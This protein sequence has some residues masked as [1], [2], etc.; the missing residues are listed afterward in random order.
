MDV[1]ATGKW[2]QGNIADNAIGAS[3]MADD[4]VGVAELSATGTASATTFLRGD[5]SWQSA[6]PAADSI[7]NAQINTSAAIAQSKLANVAYYTSS[8]TAPTS[9]TPAAGNLW[10]DSTNLVMKHYDGTSW[11]TMTNQGVLTGGTTSTFGS[12]TLHTFTS[13]GNIVVADGPKTVDILVVAGGGGGG[14]RHASGAGGGG[15]IYKPSHMLSVGTHAVVIGA[16]GIGGTGQGTVGTV[17]G[18]TTVA[19]TAFVAKGGGTQ[20]IDIGQD[21]MDGGSGGGA[22]YDGSTP[23]TGGA[24]IQ[25]SQPGDSGT[26]GFGFAGGNN[27]LDPAPIGYQAAGG[28]GAGAVGGNTAPSGAGNTNFGG[29]GKDMSATYGTAVGASGIF[30][31]GGGGGTS[32]GT[33][34]AGG[35]GG[36]GAGSDASNATAGTVNTGGGGGGGGC[37]SGPGPAGSG[38]GGNGGSGI[39]IVRY[40]T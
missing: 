33:A 19:T 39:V 16:G 24:S 25:S 40:A 36:G 11:N 15:L 12:Y 4:A 22:G 32:T 17:G 7:V 23:R 10:Y 14:S 3:Q 34:G 21:G 8:A 2:P 37:C 31:G 26:Y 9:P 29:A 18:D 28:G 35:S 13:S 38:F 1:P 30:A 27:S 6:D 5:N 20:E